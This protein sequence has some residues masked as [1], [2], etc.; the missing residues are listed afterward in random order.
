[1]SPTPT[2]NVAENLPSAAT[3]AGNDVFFVLLTMETAARRPSLRGGNR[4]EAVGI[5]IV[6]VMLPTGG[7]TGG[8]VSRL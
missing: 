8:V 3:G 1:V 4:G 7:A 2:A 6:A 5:G